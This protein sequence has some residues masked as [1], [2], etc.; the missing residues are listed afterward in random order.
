LSPATWEIAGQPSGV[1]DSCCRGSFERGSSG[2]SDTVFV[3]CGEAGDP[4]DLMRQPVTL[5]INDR[6]SKRGRGCVLVTSGHKD[7]CH[8]DLIDDAPLRR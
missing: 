4:L 7:L 1:R 8:R 5:S 3:P 2:L 6:L